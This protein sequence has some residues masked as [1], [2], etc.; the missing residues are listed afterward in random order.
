MIDGVLELDL[1]SSNA[2]PG[3][4]AGP[5]SFVVGDENLLL[6][7]PIERL[8]AGDDLDDDA[9]WFNPLVLVGVA[10]SGKSHV[11]QGLVRRL[12]RKVAEDLVAY[13]TAADF[14]R[15]LQAA[16]ADK[17]LTQWR[18][19]IRRL[20]VLVVEDLQ[21]LRGQA[22]IQQ[23]LRHTIDAIV[24]DGGAVI[25]TD[26]RE[27]TALSH[28]EPGLRDRLAAGLTVRLQRPGLAARREILRLA[29]QRRGIAISDENIA[30]L[31]RREA[32]TPAELLGRLTDFES[33]DDHSRPDRSANVAGDQALMKQIIA[34]TARYFT[35]TQAALLS[36]S[37]RA[38]LVAA[39]NVVVHLARRLTELSY[40]QIG[41]S[42]GG[43]DHTT[44]MHAE[45][46][47]ADGLA[48]D[49]ATQQAIDEL[50]R[51]LRR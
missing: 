4:A 9:R 48:L 47:L 12:R 24:D 46:R 2:A 31:A 18:T 44:I 40:A 7:P 20:R 51:L 19:G 15:E 16:H 5:S 34:V 27:P 37:R 22:T 11:A 3:P 49:P 38:S 29:A 21:R 6:V 8:L 42:L 43:R 13:F 35:V 36:A 28:L 45:R 32:A 41:R 30:R 17:Q 50:D 14:G 39:R 25:V 10:G 23:E 33:S 1:P 26:Q